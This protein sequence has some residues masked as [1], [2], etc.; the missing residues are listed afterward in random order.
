MQSIHGYQ[1]LSQNGDMLIAFHWKWSSGNLSATPASSAVI[2]QISY[3]G[4][5]VATTQ[6]YVFSLF[7][8]NGYG[9]EMS[10]FYFSANTTHYY[11]GAYVISIVSYPAFIS[12]IVTFNYTMQPSDYDT[13]SIQSAN[14]INLATYILNEADR[15]LTVYPLVHLK[16]TSDVGTVLSSNGEAYF[17]SV[18]PG[19]QTLCPQLFIAQVYVPTTLPVQPYT[20]DQSDNYSHRLDNS[21]IKRGFSRLGAYVSLSW[22][23]VAG[24]VVF[25]GCLWITIKCLKKN[26]GIEIPLFIDSVIVTAVAVLIGGLF[27]TIVMIVALLAAIGL[28][29]AIHG[30]R[31]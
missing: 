13:S 3:N 26:W 7:N 1:N 24:I 23:F 6:P 30:K 11:G 21:D 4:T 5:L 18:I 27:F 20:T 16:S 17:T 9:D 28:G 8:N 22:Q 2:I 14:R 25:A 29:W 10:S 31:A 19:L 12:P 15:F